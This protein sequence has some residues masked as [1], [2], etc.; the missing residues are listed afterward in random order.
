MKPLLLSLFVLAGLGTTGVVAA[1]TTTGANT[2]ITLPTPPR[3]MVSMSI[4]PTLGADSTFQGSVQP[5]LRSTATLTVPWTFSGS[6]TSAV[7][8]PPV[9][10]ASALSQP[11]KKLSPASISPQRVY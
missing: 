4:P 6:G 9:G 11:V 8:S 7:A 10:G 5:N 2:S 1:Q 3:S